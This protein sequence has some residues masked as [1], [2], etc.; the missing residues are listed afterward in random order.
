M[1]SAMDTPVMISYGDR[2]LE[3]QYPDWLLPVMFTYGNS[4]LKKTRANMCLQDRPA[5]PGHD[6]MQHR[7]EMEVSC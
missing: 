1:N 2:G 4:G 5:Q 3:K 7:Y 6:D